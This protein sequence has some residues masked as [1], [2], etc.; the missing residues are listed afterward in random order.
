MYL[1]RFLFHLFD[2]FQLWIV[3]QVVA[4]DV[5]DVINS[6]LTS[7]DTVIDLHLGPNLGREVNIL[8]Q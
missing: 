6:I 1:V 4:G 2:F 8:V 7:L 3:V 5:A